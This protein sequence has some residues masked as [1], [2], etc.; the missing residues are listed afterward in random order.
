MSSRKRERLLGGVWRV[1]QAPLRTEVYA[2][3]GHEICRQQAHTLLQLALFR[4]WQSP[5]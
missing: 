2:L 3:V 4:S 1:G 5:H